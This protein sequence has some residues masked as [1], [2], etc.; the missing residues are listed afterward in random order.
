MLAAIQALAPAEKR[1]M[2]ISALRRAIPVMMQTAQVWALGAA[3]AAAAAVAAVF[4]VGTFVQMAV[5]RMVCRSG[6]C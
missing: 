1:N 4:D 6:T 5:L 3:A 2:L